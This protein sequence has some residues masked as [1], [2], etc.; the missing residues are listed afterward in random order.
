MPGESGVHEA[1]TKPLR[2][3]TVNVG[4]RRNVAHLEALALQH[5]ESDLYRRVRPSPTQGIGSADQPL[6]LLVFQ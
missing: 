5:L 2:S 3:S 4:L 1:S 6:S